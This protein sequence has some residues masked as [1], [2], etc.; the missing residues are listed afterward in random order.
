[1]TGVD[2]IAVGKGDHEIA[3]IPVAAGTI[4]AGYP[5]TRIDAA[6]FARLF[7]AASDLAAVV[8]DIVSA[9]GQIAP[10]VTSVSVS[11]ESFSRM[12]AALTRAGIDPD[13][14]KA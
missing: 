3:F 14:E 13:A 2:G 12:R 8:A 10:G 11:V 7:S 5:G 1:M 4:G 9:A 6:D